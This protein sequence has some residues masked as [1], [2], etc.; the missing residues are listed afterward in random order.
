MKIP[1]VSLSSNPYDAPIGALCANFNTVYFRIDKSGNY[2]S[3][4]SQTPLIPFVLT[5]I[6][7]SGIR[8]GRVVFS[9]ERHESTLYTGH[10]LRYFLSQNGVSV[11]GGIH[12]GKVDDQ[13]DH[14]L[15]RF[16]SPY[17]LNDICRGLLEH[18][19]NFIANQ[20]FIACGAEVFGEPGSI[21][22]A[23]QAAEN[24][25]GDPLGIIDWRIVEGSGI[26]RK[27]RLSAATMNTILNAFRPY[28]R[29]MNQKG[30]L[31]FKTGTLRG[32]N[33]RAG[34]LRKDDGSLCNV[35]LFLNS[36]RNSADKLLRQLETELSAFCH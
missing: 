22:K 32:I 2:R 5:K 31:F 30:G 18:S 25:A 15:L 13:L 19:N 10:L 28:Y 11:G 6:K 7:K 17:S 35:V 27:N 20:L 8:P 26:S 3:A 12:I 33:T 34:Y 1:G 24:Y 16:Y 29:L 14:L 21:K 4:E 23:V 36:P 9:H